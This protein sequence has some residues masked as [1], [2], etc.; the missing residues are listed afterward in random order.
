MT[1]PLSPHVGQESRLHGRPRAA[2]L[3]GGPPMSDR[4]VGA[5]SA[6]ARQ[7]IGA[8]IDKVY[9]HQRL[10]S[11]LAYRPPAEFEATLQQLAAGSP[12]HQTVANATCP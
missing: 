8:F 6:H 4:I 5:A 3:L 12:R 10:H 2:F 7:T 9:N 1:G 11:A